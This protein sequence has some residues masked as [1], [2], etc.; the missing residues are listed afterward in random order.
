M[1]TMIDEIFDRNY[2]AG[3]AELNAALVGLGRKLRNTVAPAF[4]AI[5]HFE[6][7]APWTSGAGPKAKA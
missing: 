7:D 1:I 2:Q 4:L 6:W 5:H 3:R